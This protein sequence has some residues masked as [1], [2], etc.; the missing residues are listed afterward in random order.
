MAVVKVINEINKGVMICDNILLKAFLDLHVRLSDAGHYAAHV[1]GIIHGSAQ[2]SVMRH[3]SCTGIQRLVC[4]ITL[5]FCV[6]A[7]RP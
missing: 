6:T 2:V 3:H 5:H 1:F 7:Y 4:M